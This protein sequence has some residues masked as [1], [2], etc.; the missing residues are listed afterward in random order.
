MNIENIDYSQVPVEATHYNYHY[1]YYFYRLLNMKWQWWCFGQWLSS[2][3]L[4]EVNY[5]NNKPLPKIWTDTFY[6]HRRDG[7]IHPP[8]RQENGI[9]YA[10][11]DNPAYIKQHTTEEQK[12]TTKQFT[13]ADLKT[14][15]ILEHDSG[16][17]AMVLLGTAHNGDIV[18]GDKFYSLHNL[19]S[20]MSNYGVV[21][22]YQPQGYLSGCW[23]TSSCHKL[24]WER[25][26]PKQSQYNEI[27]AKIETLDKETQALRKQAEAFKP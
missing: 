17:R 1:N 11:I 19:S 8:I 7:L 14:G 10:L 22:V 13:K 3:N 15:M 4:N 2:G 21:K 25:D 27:L 20:D 5:R 12:M 6:W 26:T 9:M 24:L 23:K 16:D 18:S